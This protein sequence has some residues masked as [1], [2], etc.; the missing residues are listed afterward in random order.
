MGVRVPGIWVSIQDRTDHVRDTGRDWV[1]MAATA[2]LHLTFL[3]VNLT[4]PNEMKLR[5]ACPL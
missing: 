3:D 5:S 1:N 2:A 4:T